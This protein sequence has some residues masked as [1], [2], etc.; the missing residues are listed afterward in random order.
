[1]YLVS[2]EGV[3]WVVLILYCGRYSTVLWEVGADCGVVS[4]KEAHL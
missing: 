2:Y 1:M 4:E 3:G